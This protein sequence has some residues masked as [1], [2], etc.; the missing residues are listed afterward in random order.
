MNRPVFRGVAL[1]GWMLV[2]LTACHLGGG[3]GNM[4]TSLGTGSGNTMTMSSGGGMSAGAVTGFGSVIVNGVEFD[5]ANSTV[6]LNG[7]PGP[8]ETMD[9]HRGLL[10]GMIIEVQGTFAS[11]GTTGS[12]NAITFK[13]N[14][15]GPISSVSVINAATEQLV[16]LGQTVIVDSQTAFE[17]TSFAQL[18]VG[19]VIEVSGLPDNTGIIH[20]T[21][22]EQKATSF[23]PGMEIE[24]KGSIQNLD[25]GTKTFQIHML[26]VDFASVVNLP[27]GVPANGQFVEVKGS[28]FAGS[29]LIADHIEIEDDALGVVDATEAQVEGFV[30]AMPLPDQLTVGSQSVQTTAT[31]VFAGGTAGDLAPGKKVIVQ[32]PLVGGLLTAAKVSFQLQ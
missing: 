5:I 12:A 30:T 14:L 25:S 15:E 32:G 17:N 24:V 28:T 3:G 2:A 1:A 23:V 27:T 26:T 29:T 11:N 20:A 18:T 6:M 19:N 8:D 21:L 22:I 13:D 31:T 16:V 9:P 4:A 10:V 7:S